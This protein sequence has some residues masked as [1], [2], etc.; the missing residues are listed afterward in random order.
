MP[1]QRPSHR[2]KPLASTEYYEY[3]ATTL[4]ACQH[5]QRF[6][7]YLYVPSGYEEE[8]DK[9]HPLA[10]VVHGTDRPAQQYRDSF[11]DLAE[12]NGCVIL[13]PLFPA[14]I[15]EPRE[16]DNYKFIKFHDIRF[17]HI[18]LSMVDEISQ[19]Y[20][21]AKERFLLFGFSGG[22]HFA[23]RFF[24]LHSHRL[25]GVSIGAP[26][27][28]TFLD[29]SRDWWVGIR[30]FEKHFGLPLRPERLREV[31]VQMVIGGEDTETWEIND[32][33]SPNW[34]EG[35]DAAGKTRLER[36]SA[37]RDNYERLGMSVRYDVVPGVAHEDFKVLG[38][39]KDFFSEVLRRRVTPGQARGDGA[40]RE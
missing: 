11:A 36:L 29:P 23:H 15:I 38:P 31:P 12:E 34:M 19:R 35:A 26:G 30:D 17:D 22:G 32:K 13:A 14:G 7:Y 8:A 18:L 25:M 10:V 33:D 5:D 4:F 24:Y 2:A 16:L 27:Q 6:S 20:R 3:G 39:V 37:L 9:A 21:I 40:R 28:V 1:D